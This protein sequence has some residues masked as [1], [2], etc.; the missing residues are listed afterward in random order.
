M[1]THTTF[2]PSSNDISGAPVAAHPGSAPK[3]RASF[4]E[5]E[6][7]FVTPGTGEV[8]GAWKRAGEHRREFAPVGVV[9]PGSGPWPCPLRFTFAD[10]SAEAG[11]R[12]AAPGYR[13]VGGLGK[14]RYGA[15]TVRPG[16][17]GSWTLEPWLQAHLI[18]GPPGFEPCQP[19]T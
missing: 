18:S 14:V 8:S 7:V 12:G 16:L 15:S 3:R 4:A 13:A 2:P 11:R 10:S 6:A 5:L 9:A 1:A 17:H 19:R